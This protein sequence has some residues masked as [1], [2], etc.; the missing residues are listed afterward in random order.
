MADDVGK[1]LDEC[2]MGMEVS[3]GGR[4][5]EGESSC[6]YQGEYITE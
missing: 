6:A 5:I 3:L 1:L 4:P 2:R